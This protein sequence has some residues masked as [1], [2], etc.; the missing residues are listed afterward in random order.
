MV[1]RPNLSTQNREDFDKR[2]KNLK[3]QGPF[4]AKDDK[5]DKQAA[6]TDTPA[7]G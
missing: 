7:E 6:A 1:G 3:V 2:G 4:D 5:D